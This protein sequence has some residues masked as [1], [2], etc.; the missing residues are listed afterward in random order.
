MRL[1]LPAVLY[2]ALAFSANAATPAQA[3]LEALREGSMM[4]LVVHAEP[5]PAPDTAFAD[6]GGAEHRLSEFRGRYVAVN[7]WATWC[8]PCRK[9]LP[10]LDALNREFGGD[11][12]TVATIAT[13]RNMLPA[14]T[15]LFAE[16]GVETLP[17]YLDK[18]QALARDMGVFGLPVTVIL[19]P[20][21]RE[22]A[23]MTGDAEWDGESARA[24]VRTLLAGQ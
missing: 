9:E 10:A 6:A 24:I 3:E 21:G 8:A 1:I 7:F 2:T 20:E 17:V 5:V 16:T 13:G 11:G 14:I 12:F 4:K 23:R 19:D 15:R 18:D 22:I